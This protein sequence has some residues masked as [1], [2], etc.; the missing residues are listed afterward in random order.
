M[1]DVDFLSAKTILMAH[2]KNDE[3]QPA[4]TTQTKKNWRTVRS[5]R[6]VRNA[7]N[8]IYIESTMYNVFIFR[9]DF[10][11]VFVLLC[12]CRLLFHFIFPPLYSNNKA[13]FFVVCHSPYSTTTEIFHFRPSVIHEPLFESFTIRFVS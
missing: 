2:I 3:Q 7:C 12:C 6:R 10:L 8:F 11:C 9:N 4:V 1:F 13:R 5:V